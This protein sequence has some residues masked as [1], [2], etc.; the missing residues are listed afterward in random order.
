MLESPLRLY[1]DAQFASPYAMSVFVALRE[2]QLTFELLAVDLGRGANREESYAVESLTQRV[3]TFVHG[4][5]SLSESSAITEYLDDTFPE[6]LVY[7]RDRHLRAR[8]RQLQAWLRSDLLPIRQERSTEVVFYKK[9]APA[10]TAAAELAV[11]KLYFAADRLLSRDASNLFGDW[12]I[13]DT[14]LALMLNRLIMNR[15]EVP[16]KLASYAARQW[17]RESVQRWAALDRPP[18]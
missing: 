12:C 2:K 5:F 4:D 16:A 15:D 3:P 1:A 8:A 11:Q 6:T 7:P 14:D 13:A 17:E 9:E 10:L 18:L